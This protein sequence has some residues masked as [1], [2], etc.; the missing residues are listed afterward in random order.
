VAWSASAALLSMIFSLGDVSGAHFNPAVSFAVYVSTSLRSSPRPFPR[1]RLWRY[2]L[3]QCAAATGAA[4]ASGLVLAQSNL[5]EEQFG[6]QPGAGHSLAT[7]G[8]VEVIFTTL[9]IFVVL[10][11]ATT[12]V[13]ATQVTQHRAHVAL[14]IAFTVAAGGSISGPISGGSLNPAVAL[15]LTGL[16]RLGSASVGPSLLT[17]LLICSLQ[18]LSGLLAVGLFQVTYGSRERTEEDIPVPLRTQLLAEFFGTYVLAFGVGSTACLPGPPSVW[19]PT[20]LGCLLAALVYSLAPIS[21]ANLNPAVSLCLGLVGEKKPAEV[22]K[23]AAV[24]ILAGLA[25]GI[26]CCLLFAPAAPSLGPVQPFSFVSAGLLEVLFTFLLCFAV[27]NCAVSKRT[28]PEMDGNQSYGLAI[29]FVLTAGA[30][31]AGG[32]SGAVLNPAVAIGLDIKHVGVHYGL[33]WCLF[34]CLGSVFAA[35][36]FWPLRPDQRM[37][38]E[39][40]RAYKPTLR[41]KCAAECLT[42]FIFV[43]TVG[44]CQLNSNFSTSV[45]SAHAISNN[46]NNAT[47]AV[48][49]ATIAVTDGAALLSTAAREVPGAASAAI[50]AWPSAACMMVLVYCLQHVSGCYSNPAVTLALITSGRNYL[51]KREGGFYIVAQLAGGL[52][53]GLF[54]AG[55]RAATGTNA[56]LVAPL[57]G[58]E[59]GPVAAGFA[60]MIFT[61]LLAYVVLAV[62]TTT[63]PANWTTKQRFHIGLAVGAC[64]V[65]GGIAALRLS[66]G[67]LGPAVTLGVALEAFNWGLA[68][69]FVLWQLAGALLAGCLFRLTHSEEFKVEDDEDGDTVASRSSVF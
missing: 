58:D 55:F 30:H 45:V 28:N 1:D 35:S 62:C 8:F 5:A 32:I 44:L 3:A 51:S 49:A 20:A 67:L 7:A 52:L 47:D 38:V 23:F 33:T 17:L 29:G 19:T 68:H 31:A 37:P 59:F 21:G 64:Y 43:T 40:F 26:S 66:G 14:S 24:Q 34:Q 25:A 56:K 2:F 11:T 16:G 42:A 48:A 22:W 10:A 39:E 53:A 27:L 54:C 61:A 18:M 69:I 46:N 36:V 41:T 57:P 6:V 13:P 15:G 50:A 9:L 63:R 4:V 60:E 12:A 65:V